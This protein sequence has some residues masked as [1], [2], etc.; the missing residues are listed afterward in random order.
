MS[1]TRLAVTGVGVETAAGRGL[2]ALRAA[3][4]AGRSLL[5]PLP[6]EVARDLPQTLGARVAREG[7]ARGLELAA[8]A[9]ED[10]LADLLRARRAR[11][12]LFVGSGLG[13]REPWEEALAAG[14]R[15]GVAE[16]AHAL[17]EELAARLGLGGERATFA[18][19]CA[20]ALCALEAARAA[21]LRGRCEAALVLGIETLSRTIQGGFCALE[22]LSTANEPGGRPDDGILLGGGA[23]ALLLE[24][25]PAGGL[26]LRGQACVADATHATRPDPA[27]AG[28]RA[29]AAHALEE[30]ALAPADLGWIAL[31]APASPAYRAAYAAAL[32]ALCGPGWE[33][34]AETW[35]DAVG[36]LLAASGAVGVAWGWGRPE[37]GLALTVGF[38]GLNGATV[39]G[40]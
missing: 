40:P 14:A 16:H 20:S 15:P 32:G 30:A 33:E 12:A 38:G 1:S 3:A 11:T 21:L 29:A 34:R 25:A 23:C 37:P 27:G 31:T 17:T 5:A 26:A 18:V 13:P 24:L 9:A 4:R 6:D 10:A 7:R 19:T 28:L 2:E 39:V 35:E 8:S 22:A 36:H